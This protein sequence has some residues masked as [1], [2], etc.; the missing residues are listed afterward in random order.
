MEKKTIE[1][2]DYNYDIYTQ[3][4]NLKI[5]KEWIDNTDILLKKIEKMDIN[6]I[7]KQIED[8]YQNGYKACMQENDFDSPCTSCE[9]Y[10]RGVEDGRNETWEAA[11]K[12]IDMDDFSAMDAG[13]D[14]AFNLPPTEAIKRLKAYE[15]KQKAENEIKV[16]DEVIDEYDEKFWVTKIHNGIAEGIMAN[17]EVTCTYLNVIERTGRHID[18]EK[19][20]DGMKE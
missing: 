18:I 4:E 10:Q 13:L 5:I 9:A 17:G 11:W 16:D 7:Q 20:L 14:T 12:I 8:A 15:E 1:N 6:N 19:I 2:M 3:I